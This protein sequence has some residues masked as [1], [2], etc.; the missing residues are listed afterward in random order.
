M[1]PIITPSDSYVQHLSLPSLQPALDH[2]KNLLQD[3]QITH[4]LGVGGFAKV[5]K[6]IGPFGKEVALKIPKTDDIM[7]TMDMEIINHFKSEAE[8]WQRLE[9]DNI[10]ILHSGKT[11]PLPHLS[12][13]LMEGGNLRQLMK[14]HSL[15]VGEAVHIMEQ[16]LKGLSYAHRM[17]SVHRDLKPENILFTSDGVA[18]ITDWGIGKFMASTSKSKSGIKG[19]LDYCAPEQFDRKK[20]GKVDWQTDIFQ[21]GIMFYE[22]LTGQNPFVGEDMAEC[23]GKVLM[24]EPKPPSGLNSDVPEELDDVILGALKKKKKDRWDTGAVMLHELKRLSKTLEKEMKS[25]E[26]DIVMEQPV[27][28][29][30][31]EKDVVRKKRIDE[32]TKMKLVEEGAVEVEPLQIESKSISEYGKKETHLGKYKSHKK[33]DVAFA[34][35]V[36]MILVLAGTVILIPIESLIDFDDDKSRFYNPEP[37]IMIIEPMNEDRYNTGEVITFIATVDYP[38]DNIQNYEWDFGEGNVASGKTATHFYTSSYD[39]TYTVTFSV[40]V[41]TGNTYSETVTIQITPIV[42]TLPEKRDGMGATYDL[43]STL[44]LS[45]PEGIKLFSEESNDISITEMDLQGSGNQIVEIDLPDKEVEDGFLLP[46]DVYGRYVTISQPLRGNGTIK[47]TNT[48]NQV[49]TGEMHLAGTMDID[50]SNYFDLTTN[51]LIKSELESSMELYSEY[52]EETPYSVVD[53]IVNY[54]DLSAPSMN[55]DITTMRDNRTFCLGDVEPSGLGGRHYMW[56]IDETDNINNIPVLKIDIKF[57]RKLLEYYGISQH[58]AHL[59]VADGKALPLK[60]HI[61]IV[62]EE[63]GSMFS[64]DL[65]GIMKNDTYLPGTSTISDLE[66]THPFNGTSHHIHRWDQKDDDLDIDFAEIDYV[67]AAGNDSSSF[68]IEDAMQLVTTD[69][70]FTS[71]ISEH[72]EAFGIDSRCNVTDGKKL[73]NITF[74]EKKSSQGINFLVYDDGRISS[75]TV[76]IAELSRDARDIGE[77]LSYSAGIYVF[78]KHPV[79]K[80][81]FFPDGKIDLTAT[82]IGAGVRLPTLSVEAFYT[83][84]VNNLDFGF[85]LSSGSKTDQATNGHMAVLNGR[86]GQILYIMDHKETA[87]LLVVSSVT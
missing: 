58:T 65:M 48:M 40:K 73:W 7:A 9:H 27:K 19:T 41:A 60:Y 42:I 12:M 80:D 5:Y 29:V 17:A 10:V 45:D 21:I 71:F 81:R 50:N 18:K 8:L 22:M 49:I 70:T 84:N 14:R 78:R 52:D 38:K 56:S 4:I 28:G 51:E 67:P 2:V 44:F 26:W 62:Q 85:F 37:N 36:M 20:Y 6:A 3:Y 69:S 77:V 83:G 35:G 72:D 79:I 86:T 1:S 68:T 32:P 47:Y 61:N 43:I 39:R 30:I 24:Y 82:S 23:M 34:V 63:D 11:A 76:D 13:E 74:G 53:E 64:L 54:Q 59:W 46:H 25:D 75:R 16:I 66:C 57:D 55:I 33:R 87:P 31:I 15:T